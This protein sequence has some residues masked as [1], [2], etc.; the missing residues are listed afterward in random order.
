MKDSFTIEEARAKDYSEIL[1]LISKEF[2]Y[3]SLSI[4]ELRQRIETGK[5]V[6]FTASTKTRMAGFIEIEF[7]EGSE[8]RINGLTV[9]EEF[10]GQN[11]AKTLLQHAINYLR[12]KGIERIMLLVKQSNETAKALYKQFGFE[13][14]GLYHKQ[15]EQETVEEMELSLLEERPSYAA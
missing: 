5:V 4:E 9:K 13:F 2:T 6:I 15:L 3:F 11:A 14:I 1:G 10:R 8:A 7:F 12:Q